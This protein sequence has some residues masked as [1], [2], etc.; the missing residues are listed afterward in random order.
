[1]GCLSHYFLSTPYS[2]ACDGD[3]IGKTSQV[4]ARKPECDGILGQI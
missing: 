4:G 3:E 1:M 2:R